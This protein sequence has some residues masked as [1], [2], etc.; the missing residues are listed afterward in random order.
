ML[1]LHVLLVFYFVQLFDLVVLLPEEVLLP[2]SGDLL[3]VGVVQVGLQ[4]GRFLPET[5]DLVA[6]ILEL[7]PR[8]V[9]SNCKLT[10]H[11]L[12]HC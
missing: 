1:L 10:E 5:L 12:G 2:F 4:L 3:L 11:L 9:E 6:D 8:L 7:G